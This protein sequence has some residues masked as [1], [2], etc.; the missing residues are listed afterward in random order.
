LEGGSA[1]RATGD[2][3]PVYVHIGR[4][5]VRAVDAPA[6]KAQPAPRAAL[7][8]PSLEAHLRARDRAAG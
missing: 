5:D 3:G 4:I 7:G 8:K 6:P 2:P 1:A